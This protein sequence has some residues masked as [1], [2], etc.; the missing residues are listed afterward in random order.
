MSD[1]TC[2]SLRELLGV[3]VVGAIEPAERSL[4]DAHLD[5]CH[6]CREELAGL[7]VLPALLHRVAL[8]EAEHL[9]GAD[10]SGEDRLAELSPDLL[11]ALLR[12]VSAGRKSRRLRAAFTIAAVTLAV[13]GGTAAVTS[14][15]S[16]ATRNARPE[17]AVARAGTL[18]ATVKYGRSRWG[19]GTEMF[20]HVTGLAQWSRCKFWVVTKKGH[21][22]LVAGWTVGLDG[23]RLWYQAAVNVPKSSISEFVLTTASG[24]MVTIPVT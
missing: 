21:T 5:Y 19:P 3:Y 14:A 8:G 23:N 9:L 1:P 2:R 22:D 17:E 24:R 15:L 20:V 11:P 12:Q 16:Q 10:A 18:D 4:V 13:I 7:A 6:D